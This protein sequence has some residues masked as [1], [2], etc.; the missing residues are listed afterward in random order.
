MAAA[1]CP[2]PAVS[3]DGVVWAVGAL[4]LAS[5]LG[6]V[7][8]FRRWAESDP[9]VRAV[10][11]PAGPDPPPPVPAV[12]PGPG[13]AVLF[14]AGYHGHVIGTVSRKTVCCAC[15]LVA[16]AGQLEAFRHSRCGGPQPAAALPLFLSDG[17]RRG[18]IAVAD[19]AARERIRVL[20]E[21]VGCS[22]GP[23][24]VGAGSRG[25]AAA[26]PVPGSLR[27]RLL[28]A[29]MLAASRAAAGAIAA[30]PG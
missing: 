3:R 8:A 15:F 26:P 25:R 6:R 13:A 19:S 9:G 24:Q 7:A 21:A 16:G 2:V 11:I 29:A 20:R 14:L 12:P 1:T 18:G 23:L 22:G 4:A 5:L 27:E 28:G 17:L 10:V 30:A